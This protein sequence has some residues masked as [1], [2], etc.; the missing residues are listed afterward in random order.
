MKRIVKSRR[1]K[2]K[3]L[4]KLKR[5]FDSIFSKYIRLKYSKHGR[6]K[7]ITCQTI[8]PIEQMRLTALSK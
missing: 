7:C 8:K 3:S 1:K 2:V 5:E 6:V 4:S